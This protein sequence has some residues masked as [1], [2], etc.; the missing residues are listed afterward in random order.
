MGVVVGL[1]AIAVSLI[2]LDRGLFPP[3]DVAAWP[4][5][6][7]LTITPVPPAVVKTT[8]PDPAPSAEP[9]PEPSESTPEPSES[10]SEP[11]DSAS[12]SSDGSNHAAPQGDLSGRVIVL[13]PGHNG[14]NGA[15][16][17][18]GAQVP[19]GRGGTKACNT[20]GTSTNKGYAEHAFAW[21]VA[22]RAKATLEGLGAKV[23]LTRDSDS[24]MGP[25]VDVRGQFPQNN[26]ADVMVSIHG[27]GSDNT[28]VNGFFILYSSPALNEAQGQPSLS[29]ANDM[30]DALTGRGFAKNS[31]IKSGLSP[32]SD[33][34]GLNWSER[35]TVLL[36]LGE[37]RNAGDAAVMSSESGRQDYANA[38]ADGL[39]AW[40]SR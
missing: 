3:D 14:A 10:A 37:M 19:D 24:G 32:R 28:S 23:L 5:S 16:S 39:V 17:G 36:E 13:D 4:E 40:F 21:D 29:L 18:A 11:T 15:G 25:C 8:V 6:T 35:P 26:N 1:A 34:A 20:S 33:I 12:P 22:Q 27:D 2:L 30:V 9:T 38:I 7:N 31:A